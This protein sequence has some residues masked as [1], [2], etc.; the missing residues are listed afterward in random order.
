MTELEV[1]SLAL[2]IIP[3][4]VANGLTSLI[5]KAGRSIGL[6][7]KQQ[8]RIRDFVA[9]SDTTKTALQKA[10]AAVAR[11]LQTE[12]SLDHLKKYLVS[13]ELDVILRQLYS[14]KLVPN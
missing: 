7:E 6:L 13:P 10:S 11:S 14:A 1:A 2:S 12:E 4:V 3:N 9:Q 8:D 5:A